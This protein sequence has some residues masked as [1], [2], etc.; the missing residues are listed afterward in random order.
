ML[1]CP[2][3]PS[4]LNLVPR[5]SPFFRHDHLASSSIQLST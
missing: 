2:V 5:G 4:L 3:Y 1:V